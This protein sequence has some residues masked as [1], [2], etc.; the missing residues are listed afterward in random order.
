LRR[1][2]T[3]LAKSLGRFGAFKDSGVEGLEEGLKV[4]VTS[5]IQ[6]LAKVGVFV[7]PVGQLESWESERLAGVGKTRK[8]RWAMEAA[9]RIEAAGAQET[10]LWAF[11]KQV[12]DH[13][14]SQGK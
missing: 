9:T 14:E 2:V 10:G 13:L 3:A 1:E 4:M 7:V 6:S 11:M 12:L 5:A 8:W